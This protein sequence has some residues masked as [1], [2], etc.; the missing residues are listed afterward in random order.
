MNRRQRVHLASMGMK[1]DTVQWCD[2]IDRS[3]CGTE[4]G[5]GMIR[6]QLSWRESY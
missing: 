4:E 1:H 3:T 6:R 2:D 5:K